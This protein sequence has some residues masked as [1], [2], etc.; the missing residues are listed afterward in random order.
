MPV[1]LARSAAASHRI[2]ADPAETVDRVRDEILDYLGSAVT[3]DQRDIARGSRRQV[4][5]TMLKPAPRFDPTSKPQL[6][7]MRFSRVDES[8]DHW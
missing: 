4:P 8:L 1:L 6:R 7:S 5:N 2:D 3:T